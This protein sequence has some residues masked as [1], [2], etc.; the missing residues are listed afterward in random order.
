MEFGE[1]LEDYLSCKREEMREKFNRVLPSNELLFDRWEKARFL[2]CGNHTSIYDSSVIMGE[3]LIGSDVWIGPFTLLEGV[4]GAI[5]IGDFCHISSGVQI[6]TH[7]TAGYVLTG[8]KAPFRAGEVQIGDH[9]YIGGMSIVTRGVSIG[10]HCVIGANSFVNHDVPAYSIAFGSPARI[11]GK[12]EI[13]GAT[14]HF[15]YFSPEEPA[16]TSM[17]TP[18]G[19]D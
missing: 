6:V 16:D 15:C 2:D 5:K 18:A 14:V 11:M 3:V 19:E 9:T 4:G 7:D 12:V 1:Q 17:E 8:G 10:H 13:E